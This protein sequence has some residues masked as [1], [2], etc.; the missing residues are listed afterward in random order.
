MAFDIC[1]DDCKFVMKTQRECLKNGISYSMGSMWKDED[2]YSCYCGNVTAIC[3]SEYVQPPEV[4]R[5][6]EAVFDRGICTY[7]IY[8]KD[9]HDILCN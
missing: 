8:R 4:P 5:N 2:C 1:S 6:C 9:N 3:C 7:K